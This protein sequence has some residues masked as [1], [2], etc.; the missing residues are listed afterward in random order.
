MATKKEING[1]IKAIIQLRKEQIKEME[2][3]IKPLKDNV[4]IGKDT[5][6]GKVSP[7]YF[8]KHSKKVSEY[9]EKIRS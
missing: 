7:E 5:I 6:K 1:K 2:K 4:Q 3:L 9:I 8:L